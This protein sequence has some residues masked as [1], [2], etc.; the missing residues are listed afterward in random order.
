MARV[1][2]TTDCTRLA[3]LACALP[4]EM[5]E[6]YN[7][8]EKLTLSAGLAYKGPRV[9]IPRAVRP[10]ILDRFISHISE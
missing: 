3:R 10:E 8:A 7:F 1:V 2:V 6:Y 9:I 4:T 5:P